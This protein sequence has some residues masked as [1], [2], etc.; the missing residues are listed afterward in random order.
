MGCCDFCDEL[1]E[2]KVLQYLMNGMIKGQNLSGSSSAW[3]KKAEEADETGF[4]MV[5]RLDQRAGVFSSTSKSW[6]KD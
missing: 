3:G 6:T 2:G 5:G 4:K 1:E